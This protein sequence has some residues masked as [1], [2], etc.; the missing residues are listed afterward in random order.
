MQAR[1]TIVAWKIHC[2]RVQ[3]QEASREK[4][5]AAKADDRAKR[6]EERVEELTAQLD[7][8][9]SQQHEVSVGQAERAC[10]YCSCRVPQAC[11]A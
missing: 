5:K 8:T 11:R 1:T 2:E 7:A 9:R 4:A 3:T 6:A 10:L